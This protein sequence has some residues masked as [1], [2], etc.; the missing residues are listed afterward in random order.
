MSP[1]GQA[2]CM[3][4]QAMVVGADVMLISIENSGHVY[5]KIDDREI[6]PELEDI[7]KLIADYIERQLGGLAFGPCE[8]R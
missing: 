5:K 6:Q 1:Y 2:Q 4:E 3:Y 8:H 7:L